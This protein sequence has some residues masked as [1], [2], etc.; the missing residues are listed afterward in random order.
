MCN[1]ECS[2][3]NCHNTND[4]QELRE[5]IIKSIKNKNPNAFEPRIINKEPKGD[6]SSETGDNQKKVHIIGCHCKKSGCRKRYCECFQAGTA[7][8]PQCSCIDCCNQEE[9]IA[10]RSQS[11]LA[12]RSQT[13]ILEISNQN[14]ISQTESIRKQ[15]V[16]FETDSIRGSIKKQ[17]KAQPDSESKKKPMAQ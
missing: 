1:P 14:L 4:H 3:Q 16:A 2:C 17:P 9:H 6:G 12:D 11:Q 15:T 5:K 10:A 8:G 7:C 13:Q